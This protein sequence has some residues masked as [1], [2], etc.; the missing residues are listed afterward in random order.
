MSFKLSLFNQFGGLLAST[1]VKN[2]MG[3]LSFR[4]LMYD[5]TVDPVNREFHGPVI[6]VF[7]HEY[8]LVPFYLRGNSNTAILTSRHR[9][10]NWVAE[11]AGHLG[12]ET[13]RGSTFRG[14]STALLELLRSNRKNI[15]IACDGPR[16]PR[17]K[18]AQGPIY[19]SS[20]L[21]IPLLAYGI[22]YDRPW[23]FKSWDRFA[24]PRPR[25]RA[26][27]MVSPRIQIPPEL[28]RKGVERY[29]VQVEGV[30][31]QLT[32]EAESWARKGDRRD[33]QIGAFRQPSPIV[34]TD[35]ATYRVTTARQDRKNAA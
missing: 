12:F 3:S 31:N 35:R 34:K 9:D 10:A 27:W 22:G 33:G 1:F 16:G 20:K 14:A 8:L 18:M 5:P 19:L 17:R 4:S 6:A 30:L 2:W 13:V 25:T 24:V 23:R 26:C 28:C 29:R 21:Q 15:G 32:S 11:A 7:W